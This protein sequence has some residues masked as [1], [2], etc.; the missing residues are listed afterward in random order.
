MDMHT[1]VYLN[2]LMTA[3]F[4]T[5]LVASCST[6]RVLTDDQLRLDRN[7]V[8]ITNDK[9]FPANSL[10][11]YIKQQPNK[12]YF[13]LKPLLYMYN[14]SGGSDKGLGKIWKSLGEAPVIY[15]QSMVELSKNSITARLDNLGYFDSKV[16]SELQL[17]G[18]N[19]KVTYY[20]T[21]G[22]RYIIDSIAYV[23]PPQSKDFEKDFIADTSGS[24]IHPG[25][26]LSVQQLSEEVE[27]SVSVLREKGYYALN[28]T[29]Y[30]FVADTVGKD[31][32]AVLEY[33]ISED[34]QKLRKVKIGEVSINYPEDLNIKE[35]V[36]KG[37][38][39][40]KPGDEYR[41]STIGNT[42]SRFSS[43]K[44]FNTVGIDLNQV[45]DTKVNC[46]INLT[47]S[48]PQGFK[49][50]L[51]VS[52][53]SSGLMGVSPQINFYHK[54]IFGGG[55]WLNIGFIGNFQFKPKDNISSNELGTSL[56]LSIPR[57]LGLDY[58]YFKGPNIPRTEFNA[59]YNYQN[60]PEYT[61]NILSTSFGYSGTLKG[62]FYYQFYP[63][64]VNYVRL[65]N[66]NPSFLATLEKNPFM[67]YSYQ[68]H[69]DIGVGGS[70]FYNSSTDLVPTTDYHAVRLSADLSGNVISLFKNALTHNESGEALVMGAPFSQYAR[71]ELSLTKA[72]RFGENDE[73]C[74]AARVL[75]GIGVAYGNST[76]LPYEKQF[77]CG[78]A[79]S[80]RGWQARALGPGSSPLDETFS[81]PSQT[82]DIKLEADVEY[83]FPLIW[84][85]EGA[86]FAEVGN[87]WKGESGVNL[88]ELAADWGIG[89]RVNMDFLV[90]RIDWGIRLRDPSLSENKWIDP[91]TALQTQ[92]SALHFG[93]GYPF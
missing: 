48:K 11:N 35:S 37:V 88:A 21:L 66:M 9:D 71:A 84:K 46:E 41:E 73:N 6:T 89:V 56:N 30:S 27:R 13:G 20:V 87:V 33:I 52:T 32:K 17:K 14:W 44:I 55:E 25:D 24:K 77:Y 72:F 68:D 61:R 19:A 22:K 65:F 64:Q 62:R 18:R 10:E 78:G 86:L 74:L 82:G 70:V 85:L 16:E 63:L 23:I 50:N 54:N 80:M 81:I 28:R 36:L 93:V 34:E 43:L 42:Y 31:G 76:A 60:R 12:S 45:S 59:S 7:S 57:F 69:C 4:A 91:V 3:C 2:L 51:E 38:N 26:Y 53:N 1:K 8:V 47:K 90:L 40:I 58:R 49:T 92:G 29:Y 79:G 39:L 75:G 83:R 15:D 5:L 67:K